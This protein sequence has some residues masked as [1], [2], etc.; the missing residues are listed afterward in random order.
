MIILN[1]VNMDTNY[2]TS[3]HKLLTLDGRALE[4]PW[5]ITELSLIRICR[6]CS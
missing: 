5:G 6:V 3:V 4:I 2:K 1:I